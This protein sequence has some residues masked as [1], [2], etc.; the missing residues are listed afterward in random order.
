MVLATANALSRLFFE[1]ILEEGKRGVAFNTI[2]KM[3]HFWQARRLRHARRPTLLST[4]DEGR[5]LL[6]GG[7]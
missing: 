5:P 2:P 7:A 1:A 6:A 3:R 4:V